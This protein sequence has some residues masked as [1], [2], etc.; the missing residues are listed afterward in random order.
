MQQYWRR[1]V[2]GIVINEHTIG[3][4]CMQPASILWFAYKLSHC[5]CFINQVSSDDVIR[6]PATMT[7]L[8]HDDRIEILASSS[9]Q[10]VASSPPPTC[11]ATTSHA[12]IHDPTAFDFSLSLVTAGMG[13]VD[14]VRLVTGSTTT[15]KGRNFR[16]KLAVSAAKASASKPSVKERRI[17]HAVMAVTTFMIVASMIL[18]GASLS[19]SDH[20]D[21]MGTCTHDVPLKGTLCP[22]LVTSS[23]SYSSLFCPLP[24]ST[25]DSPA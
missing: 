16:R 15:S 17:K 8:N 25:Q 21:D 23:P 24:L 6:T 13:V 11:A 2:Q 10:T 22:T 3:C 7:S 19:L 9:S 4:I 14:P 5:A 20:I 18:V 1:V 12:A